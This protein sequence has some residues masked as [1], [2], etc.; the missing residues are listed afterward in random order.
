MQ[1][2]LDKASGAVRAVRSGD[3]VFVGGLM[4]TDGDGRIVAGGVREQA[5][6][7]FD[8]LRELVA[9]TGASMAD[10]VK[11][12]VYFACEGDEATV[13]RFM[14]DL[15]AVRFGYFPDPGPT[16]TEVRCGLERE[17][18]LLLVDAW[19]VVGGA[20]E[21]LAPEGHWGWTRKGPFVHGW[22]VGDMLFAGGHR[23]LDAAGNVLGVRDI[24]VQ[25]LAG[26]T[27]PHAA[28]SF[29]EMLQLRLPTSW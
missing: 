23:S 16:T 6:A 24:E 8:T 29:L 5:R 13:Q 10:V 2:F 3:L 12:N 27:L 28:Q 26:R 18:A 21:L 22:K 25:T 9:E 1:R 7:I 14:A 15:D 17:G 11:H 19:I 20:K 4:A